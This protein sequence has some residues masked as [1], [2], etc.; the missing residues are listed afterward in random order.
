MRINC[1]KNKNIFGFF[2]Y[3]DPNHATTSYAEEPRLYLQVKKE[4]AADIYEQLQAAGFL[5]SKK[6]EHIQQTGLIL[7]QGKENVVKFLQNMLETYEL[8]EKQLEIIKTHCKYLENSTDINLDLLNLELTKFQDQENKQEK[9]NEQDTYRHNLHLSLSKLPGLNPE[10]LAFEALQN[11]KISLLS[12]ILDLENVNGQSKRIKALENIQNQNIR[13]QTTQLQSMIFQEVLNT[14]RQLRVKGLNEPSLVF[15]K[16]RIATEIAF[17]NK[18]HDSMER[19]AYHIGYFDG[20]RTVYSPQLNEHYQRNSLWKVFSEIQIKIQTLL[21]SNAENIKSELQKMCDEADSAFMNAFEEYTTSDLDVI[22]EQASEQNVI[23]ARKKTLTEILNQNKALTA[24]FGKFDLNQII[25]HFA[26]FPIPL[27]SLNDKD[28]SLEQKIIT[29]EMTK[30][31][32]E[33]KKYFHPLSKTEKFDPDLAEKAFARQITIIVNH[34]SEIIRQ[35]TYKNSETKISKI[36]NFQIKILKRE[37]DN[38]AKIFNSQMGLLKSYKDTY[39]NDLAALEWI[40]THKNILA[41]L[42]EKEKKRMVDAWQNSQHEKAVTLIKIT[43]LNYFS[44]QDRQDFKETQKTLLDI[45]KWVFEVHRYP[46]QNKI[47]LATP[48]IDT[49]KNITY[50]LKQ[51]LDKYFCESERLGLEIDWQL[52]RKCYEILPREFFLKANNTLLKNKFN[53]TKEGIEKIF[54]S[55][56]DKVI[57]SPEKANIFKEKKSLVKKQY[58]DIKENFSTMWLDWEDKLEEF[59]EELKK[60]LEALD[61]FFDTQYED[62][63]K[64][65]NPSPDAVHKKPRPA[66]LKLFQPPML[67]FSGIEA[68][69]DPSPSNSPKTPTSNGK[70]P[71]RTTVR[72]SSIPTIIFQ[73]PTSTDLLSPRRNSSPRSNLTNRNES[74]EPRTSTSTNSI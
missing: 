44:S 41:G 53:A 14:Y 67:D 50:R 47:T 39:K 54:S 25:E 74:T 11:K 2:I 55:A 22:Q 21:T 10:K 52:Q 29:Q 72:S 15:E 35:I 16:L 18:I 28:E 17:E 64:T 6:I 66:S 43:F 45:L 70:A 12:L 38:L 20:T 8:S 36:K 65:T 56:K 7:I 1:K 71:P 69:E 40:Y 61:E 34:L 42:E 60:T 4:V 5:E 9:T 73:F 58:E 63:L 19:L 59:R 13:L 46:Q 24:E 27:T 31:L 62:W 57:H 48:Q 33:Y 68:S 23:A 26:R 30:I 3:P 37:L 51:L 32:S 49:L